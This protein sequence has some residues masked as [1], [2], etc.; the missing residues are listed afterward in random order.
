MKLS[1]ALCTDN[2]EAYLGGQLE[3][4][5]RQTRP[6]DELVVFDDGSTDA[7]TRILATFA[8][9]APF[10]VHLHTGHPVGPARNF[11][12]AI[13]HCSG[14]LIALSDQDDLWMPDRLARAEAA[15]SGRAGAVMSFSD[16][17]LIDAADRA[18]KRRL[19]RSIGLGRRTVEAIPED[20]LAAMLRRS[21]VTGCT[22]TFHR[23]VLEVGLPFPPTRTLCHDRWLA[24]C[25]AATGRIVPLPA[26]L[27]GYRLHPGQVT[28]KGRLGRRGRPRRR[29]HGAHLRNGRRLGDGGIVD[30]RDEA[31]LLRS[32]I[33]RLRPTRIDT[34][35]TLDEYLAFVELR[36][37]LPTA[38]SRVPTVLGQALA[39]NYRR[40]ATGWLGA[41][42]DLVRR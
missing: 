34:L 37:L 18:A 19:W 40:F 28:G 3:S 23:S 5:S 20:A 2:G 38:S 24:M 35:D 30:I 16:A 25:A 1:V 26:P 6:P 10:P 42:A 14:D 29:W 11:S 13:A 32:R 27:V 9:L 41:G 36:A 33:E 17:E 7:T 31:M 15:I 12:R 8:D 39:G 21:V 22:M 4:I